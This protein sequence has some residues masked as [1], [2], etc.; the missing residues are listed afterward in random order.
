MTCI[1]GLVEDDRVYMGCDSIGAD[2]Y[3]FF[4]RKDEK[5]FKVGKFLIGY[6]SSFRMGQL[7]RFNFEPPDRGYEDVYSYMCTKFIDAVRECLKKGGYTTVDNNEETGGCFLVGYEGRLFYIGD[8]FQVG[9]SM[10]NYLA[11]G[12][13]DLPAMG[14]LHTT[15]DMDISPEKRILK[16]LQAAESCVTT[17][18]GPFLIEYI[19]G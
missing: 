16:A 4:T 14:S 11:V 17:V 8:D 2:S 9:E 15:N 3:C 19:G 18:G 1:V 10:S 6:T 7:L 12:S 13:G 5:M